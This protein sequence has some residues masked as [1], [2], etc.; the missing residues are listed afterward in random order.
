MSNIEYRFADIEVRDDGAVIEGT[1]MPYGTEADI[2][3]MFRESVDAGAFEI[4]DVIL[5]KMHDRADPI[6]RTGG[7]GLTLTDGPDRLLLRA[8]VPEYRPDIRD[9]VKRGILKG[10]SVEM[11]VI[12]EEWP[13]QDR[14]IIRSAELRG[15]GLVDRP[16][17]GEATAA[18]VKRMKEQGPAGWW[19]IAL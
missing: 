8:E 15:V 9:M 6:A 4:R 3:G 18:I 5:N 11:R 14:R 10:L 16:A 13:T 2:A 17:Y 1:A 19:P 7:G 12:R